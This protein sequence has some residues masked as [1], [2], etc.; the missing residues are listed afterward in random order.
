VGPLLLAALLALSSHL[1]GTA[2]T[3]ALGV[4]GV[5]AL[6]L[7]LVATV[8]GS[9]ALVGGFLPGPVLAFEDSDTFDALGR[10][11][12]YVRAGLPR[13]LATRFVFFTGVVLGS[14]WRAARTVVAVLLALLIVRGVAGAEPIDRVLAIWK[15]MGTPPDADRLG[16]TTADHA[17][18]VLV[19]LALF[20]LLVLWLADLWSR[21]ACARAAA[22]LSLRQAIDGVAPDVLRAAPGMGEVPGSRA[23]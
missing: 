16:I 13:L 18:A 12:T 9:L 17:V 19:G 14:A 5:A 3:L 11:L 20:G 22:Y 6:A 8:T 2:G 4:A 21:V 15:A 1:P 23:S 7:A 10:T